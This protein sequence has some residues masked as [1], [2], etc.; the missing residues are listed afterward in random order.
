MIVIEKQIEVNGEPFRIVLS[1]NLKGVDQLLEN[2]KE[3]LEVVS[4][5]ITKD[6]MVKAFISPSVQEQTP[7]PIWEEIETDI[8]VP[9]VKR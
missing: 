2:T 5:L 4:R 1:P 3:N 7:K 6:S 8:Y 9:S